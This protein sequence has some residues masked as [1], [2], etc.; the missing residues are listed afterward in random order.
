MRK[1]AAIGILLFL[2][3]LLLRAPAGLL[4]A[5]LDD[6]APVRL[7]APKGTVWSGD[8][9]LLIN[10]FSIGRLIWTFEPVTLI[11]GRIGYDLVLNGQDISLQGHAST[12][13]SSQAAE[14][15]GDVQAS[16]VNHW[17]A[18]YDIELSGEF[19]L[20]DIEMTI[21]EQTVTEAGGRATWGGGNLTY[22]LSGKVSRATLPPMFADLGPGPVAVAFAEGEQTPLLH[23]ALQPN[24]FAKIGVTKYLTKI[25]G[26][27]WP[28]G[29]PDHAIVLEVEEQVF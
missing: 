2:L 1:A 15:T 5:V 13:F 11:G 28:G 27:P 24:G 23:A 21:I 10:G 17:L 3:F 6:S 18:A 19:A 20:N 29:D 8:A 7:L 4:N 16:F 25:L 12:N 9:T 22:I 26:N 14:I